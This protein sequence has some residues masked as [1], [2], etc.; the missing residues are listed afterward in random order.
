MT[1]NVLLT[2]LHP[3]GGIR[4]Y[5][6]YIYGDPSFTD[7]HFT[8]VAPDEGLS[9]FLAK[10]LPE[11][12][13]TVEAAA[14]GKAAYIRQMR[15][16]IRSDRYDLIQA[17][18]F[19]AGL[20]TSLASFGLEL[21][22]IVTTH[23]VFLEG[24]FQG[25]SGWFKKRA[26]GYLLGRADL[27]NPVGVDAA[28]NLAANYPRLAAK[29]RLA[30]IR[31]GINIES[32]STSERRSLKDELEITEDKVLI[33]FFGRFMGQK[34]FSTLRDAL[35]ICIGDAD[36]RDK[37][38]VVCFGWG[39]FIR[40]EQAEL[41]R[42]QLMP[43]FHFVEHTDDMAKALRG[44][45]V[46]VMPS[47]WEACPLLPMEAMV[48]GVPVIASDCI[49]M[50]EVTTKTPASRFP[51]GDERALASCI[52]DFCNSIGEQKKAAEDFRQEAAD[53]FDAR[54]TARSLLG[55]FE[56]FAQ[57]NLTDRFRGSK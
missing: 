32:F 30:P 52:R 23:D 57:E 18:G 20:L 41:D 7:F 2:A 21:P 47:R 34:G 4:T 10:A 48:A 31:N 54:R 46:A 33:G 55:L 25:L 53:R 5:F 22:L 3:S 19:S 11:G 13:C 1:K 6:R 42:L 15:W 27:I 50:K 17:H 9:E 51:V 40:E 28:D 45:D 56:S 14:E 44:V 26:I 16:H 39:G 36:L 8:L 29:G 35:A 43:W 38:R 37:L 24:R 49:G 12:R